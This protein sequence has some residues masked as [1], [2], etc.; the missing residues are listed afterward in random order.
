MKQNALGQ[1]CNLFKG[2]STNGA[3]GFRRDVSRHGHCLQAK[4][5]RRTNG[6]DTQNDHDEDVPETA[7][8]SLWA[9]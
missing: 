3:E 4:S 5:N 9:S 7:L 1:I 8:H 2:D 6:R